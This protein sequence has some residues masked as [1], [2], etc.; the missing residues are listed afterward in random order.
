M[1]VVFKIDDKKNKRGSSLPTPTNPGEIL[2]F[3]GSSWKTS[4]SRDR[5]GEFTGEEEQYIITLLQVK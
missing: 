4:G 3:D 1:N 2:S 5:I